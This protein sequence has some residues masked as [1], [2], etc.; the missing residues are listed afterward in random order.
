MIKT[1]LT[2]GCA[3]TLYTRGEFGGRMGRQ[4][5]VVALV[6][7]L[8]L[9]TLL[10]STAIAHKKPHKKPGTTIVLKANY[11]RP[12]GVAVAG[13]YASY[14]GTLFSPASNT[15]YVSLTIADQSGEPVFASVGQDVNGDKQIGSDE[16]RGSFCGKTAS[17]LVIDPK[18]QI[19]VFVFSGTCSDGTQSVATSGT[20]TAVL[21]SGQK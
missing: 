12:D 19:T 20:I 6:C 1:K 4:A 5:F 13:S 17:P 8:A 2:R 21:S 18:Y 9:G 7:S 16:F 3:P 10:P 11:S 15:P 14:G